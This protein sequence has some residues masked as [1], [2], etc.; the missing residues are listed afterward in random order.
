[1]CVCASVQFFHI[2]WRT[3]AESIKNHD[4][5]AYILIETHSIFMEPMHFH[6]VFYIQAHSFPSVTYDRCTE[7]VNVMPI[8]RVIS[9]NGNYSSAHCV[10]DTQKKRGKWEREN[11]QNE[12]ILKAAWKAHYF[13]EIT[14]W[15]STVKM[16]LVHLWLRCAGWTWILLQEHDRLYKRQHRCSNKNTGQI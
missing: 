6:F 15:N 4:I 16:Q 8:K 5:Y 7:G 12:W 13:V 3:T 2:Y 14:N 11:N 10:A 1:M 9:W